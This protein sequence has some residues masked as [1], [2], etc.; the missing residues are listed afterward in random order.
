MVDCSHGNSRKD[1]RRQ[2]YV[3]AS[4]AEQVAGGSWR[5]F[6]VMLESHLIEGRQD[7]A[8]GQRATFG[9]SITDACLSFEQTE[10]IL[11]Q[12]AKA[13]QARGKV[14]AAAAAR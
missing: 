6:G 10:P 13:Q 5:I 7:Y 1:H 2:A 4:V 8:P 9:Q 14:S 11:E 3:A 12:L